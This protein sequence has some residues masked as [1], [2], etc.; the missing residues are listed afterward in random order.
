MINDALRMQLQEELEKL[1][2][3][4][5]AID[6]Q[7][8][9]FFSSQIKKS[10]HHASSTPIMAS[11]KKVED[12]VPCF[13][14]VS[15]DS[16]KLVA[17]VNE[18]LILSD[19]MSKIVRRLDLLQ[20]RAQQALACT[21]DIINLKECRSSLQTAIETRDLPLAVSYIKQ[22]HD[23]DEDAAMASDDIGAIQQAERE[24]KVLVRE[25]FNKAIGESDIKGVIL[26]CPLL[27]TLG[28]EAEARDT[29]LNF[30]ENNI[31]IAVSA[32]LAV[33]G[34]SEENVGET[35]TRLLSNLFNSTYLIFQQYLPIIIQGMENSHGDFHFIRRLHQRCEKQSGIVL[36]RY[37]KFRNLKVIMQYLTSPANSKSLPLKAVQPAPTSIM[38]PIAEMHVLLDE[39]ALMIQYCCMYF[40]YLGQ[41][42]EGAEKRDRL[43]TSIPVSASNSDA[44]GATTA[45]V[46]SQS[47]D[48]DTV[49]FGAP[50]EFSQMVDELVNRYYMEGEIYLMR[51][52][53]RGT[54][55]SLADVGNTGFRRRSGD[56]MGLD[57]CFFVLKRC[58]QRALVTG[59]I[60]ASCA[61]LRVA[62]DLVSTD[63]LHAISDALNVATNKAAPIIQDHAVKFLRTIL[64]SDSNGLGAS[65]Q[66]TDFYQN[67]ATITNV[68]NNTIQGLKTAL[69][70][71]SSLAGTNS[72]TSTK[73][74]S[75]EGEADDDDEDDD[76]KQPD[77][78]GVDRFM[79]QFELV[80]VCGHYC[81]RLT[82]EISS[83]G[84][85]IYGSLNA[86]SQ[87]QSSIQTAIPAKDGKVIPSSTTGKA[88]KSGASDLDKLRTCRDEL[89]AAKASFGQVQKISVEK[90]VSVANSAIKDIIAAV[91]GRS[92]LHGGVKFDLADDQFER[93]HALNFLPKSL[94]TP[95][96][97]LINMCTSH[98]GEASKD[99]AIALITDGCCEKLELLVSQVSIIIFIYFQSAISILVYFSFTFLLFRAHFISLEP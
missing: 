39:L 89:E 74:G 41:L 49:V 50:T 51:H 90:V 88:V 2:S 58:G 48:L 80:E 28:L 46:G 64:E 5:A 68:S 69:S 52:G 22:V 33:E 17:Q 56:L 3:D 15:L 65:T 60:H 44:P 6:L 47:I 72:S 19:K 54:I 92:G 38:P 96:E 63:L 71:A 85:L 24:I 9:Q 42:C 77:I 21:E 66:S 94:T 67:L 78:W 13:E 83:T 4:D 87:Q 23:I 75:N 59:N 12:F 93:Q 8:R 62:A 98:L 82:K 26:L 32:D 37:V 84:E 35:Y 31:F 27:Q 18:C 16:A 36:K 45:T 20:I 99:I 79:K 25:D 29:F 91:L 57:E 76:D 97:V 95:I 30:M 7:L 40:K 43:S 53:L 11:M 10:H 34:A 1:K 14:A 86:Q 73:Q 70:L 81:E 61:V 55:I